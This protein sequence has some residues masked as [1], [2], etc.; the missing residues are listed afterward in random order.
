MLRDL[1]VSVVTQTDEPVYGASVDYRDQADGHPVRVDVGPVPPG[2]VKTVRI[3]VD[4]AEQRAD[5]QPGQLLPVLYFRDTRN[6]W[7]YRDA[8]GYLR[9]D[10]G[11]GNDGFS[12]RAARL[13]RKLKTSFGLA[14]GSVTKCL[15]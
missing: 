11:P 13:L 6:R 1:I 9:P 10:P 12:S 15:D 14:G 7:W 3:G 4:G 8:V 2:A 5:W